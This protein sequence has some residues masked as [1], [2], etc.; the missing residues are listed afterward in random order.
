MADRQRQSRE[1]PG[2]CIL[3]RD[4]NKQLSVLVVPYFFLLSTAIYWRT[5]KLTLLEY[6]NFLRKG[7]P[8]TNALAKPLALTVVF[9]GMRV[10]LFIDGCDIVRLSMLN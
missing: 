10:F 6:E 4:S 1:R 7:S 9:L 2:R 3:E 5:I 8:L